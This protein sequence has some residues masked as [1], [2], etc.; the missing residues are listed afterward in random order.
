MSESASATEPLRA[1]PRCLLT[2]LDDGT[3]VVLNLDTKF[4]FTLNATAIVLW[5]A[6]SSG[7]RTRSEL[8]DSLVQ[9]FDVA[10]EEASS[11]VALLVDEL[12]AEG[13]VERAG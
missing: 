5:K 9:E 11:D 1:H 8:V 6:L 13:L 10:A 12:V 3:G 2:E 4:Y 7:P